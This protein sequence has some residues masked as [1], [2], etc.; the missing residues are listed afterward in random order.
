MTYEENLKDPEIQAA[1]KFINTTPECQSIL[2]DLDLLPE[3][4]MKDPRQ[5]MRTLT[6][7]GLLQRIE[8]LEKSLK[9]IHAN[10]KSQIDGM[11]SMGVPDDAAER[12][13]A[14]WYY[15]ESHHALVGV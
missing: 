7:V 12:I 15:E 8:A 3:Q 11:N 1:L 5:F 14:L 9:V 6:F 10:A 13:A 2:Y 4:T